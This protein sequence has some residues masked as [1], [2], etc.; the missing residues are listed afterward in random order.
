MLIVTQV[1]VRRWKCWYCS[2]CPVRPLPILSSSNGK[3][4]VFEVLLMTN[5]DTVLQHLHGHNFQVLAEGYGEW[6]GSI[7]N[8]SNPMRRDV[9]V[10][11]RAAQT[12]D[13]LVPAYIVLQF[14]TDN[15][16]IWPLHCHLAWHNSA[17]LFANF[18]VRQ[19][20]IEDFEI[21][22]ELDQTCIDWNNFNSVMA[23]EQPDSGV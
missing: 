15:T 14:F 23:D 11:N 8:P 20:E 7:T 17:G 9:H 6:D 21:P 16:G 19:S 2:P 18:M 10:L 4:A 1:S 5:T 22:E 12:D 3:Q 13:G